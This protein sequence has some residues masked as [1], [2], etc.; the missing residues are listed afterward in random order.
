MSIEISKT[1]DADLKRIIGDNIKRFRELKHESQAELAKLL[2]V[3]R[4]AVNQWEKGRTKPRLSHLRTLAEHFEVPFDDLMTVPHIS[5]SAEA[6]LESGQA[7]VNVL[8]SA[9]EAIDRDILEKR[10]KSGGEQK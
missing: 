5:P 2:D 4:S 1:P 8:I 3:D 9:Q 6:I 10:K 7:M